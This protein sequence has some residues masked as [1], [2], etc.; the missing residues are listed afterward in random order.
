MFSFFFIY[1]FSFLSLSFYVSD[2][3]LAIMAVSSLLQ[4]VIHTQITCRVLAKYTLQILDFLK[5]P[6]HCQI[7]LHHLAREPQKSEPLRRKVLC[8]VVVVTLFCFGFY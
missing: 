3:N 1:F 2:Y 4:A 7:N 5:L 8:F 6:F